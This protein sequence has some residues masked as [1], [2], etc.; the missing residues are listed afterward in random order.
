[1]NYKIIPTQEELYPSWRDKVNCEKKEKIKSNAEL[2]HVCGKNQG[3]C[4]LSS[5][6]TK[7]RLGIGQG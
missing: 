4:K 1:M 2:C 7:K 3:A 6:Y 5:S